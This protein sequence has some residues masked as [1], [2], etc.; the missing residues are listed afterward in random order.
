MWDIAKRLPNSL[1]RIQYNSIL[2][3]SPDGNVL[4]LKGAFEHGDLVA[5]GYSL[6]YREKDGW[7]VPEKLDIAFYD[8]MD[9]GE[10][11]GACLSNDGQTVIMYFSESVSSNVCDIYFSQ[12]RKSGSWTKPKSLGKIINGKKTDEVS[13]FLASDG[14]TL[15]FSSNREG[16]EGSYD[17]YMSRRLDKSWKKWS[18]PKNMGPSINTPGWEAYYSIDAEGKYA[19]MVSTQN[20]LGKEDIVRIPLG[21]AEQPDPVLLVSGKVVDSKTGKGIAAEISYQEL[22]QEEIAGTARTN[23]EDGTYK[24]VLPYGKH[25]SFSAHVD[26]YFPI[27]ENIDLSK[28]DRYKEIDKELKLV[29]I[30]VGHTVRLNNIFFD[31]GKADLRPESFAE[32]NK[33]AELMT[34]NSK[35]EI[36]IS[37]HTDNVGSDEVNLELSDDR[38]HAV[39][40]YLVS[41]KVNASRISAKGYG[42]NKPIAS[43]ETEEGQQQNR[44][45]EFTILKK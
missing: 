4:F 10:F 38:A 26:G 3:V 41:K 34:E 33:V 23:P 21:E 31:F 29:P 9:M 8:E 42:K 30:E 32:L 27:S 43:N 35:M 1:N 20:S 19:Y 25:Y 6:S 16:G 7:T 13:P 39:R 2:S 24:I 40:N 22:G 14:R 18:D 15:Y 11:S 28:I 45:V 44:R 17:I 5:K 37:G 36:E 12:L